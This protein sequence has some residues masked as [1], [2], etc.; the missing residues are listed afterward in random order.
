MKKENYQHYKTNIGTDRFF[1]CVCITLIII[2]LIGW[3]IIFGLAGCDSGELNYIG[4]WCIKGIE[5]QYDCSNVVACE[6]TRLAQYR[7][8][9]E[10]VYVYKII[11][12]SDSGTKTEY[13]TTMLV[14]QSFRINFIKTAAWAG[15]EETGEFAISEE[16]IISIDVKVID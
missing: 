3:I 8:E 12:Y 11:M 6:T 13:L 10:Y 5:S 15:S 14:E 1:I 16:E 2:L 4:T 7:T 9:N